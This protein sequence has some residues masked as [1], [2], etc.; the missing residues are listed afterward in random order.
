M[1]RDAGQFNGFFYDLA[2]LPVIVASAGAFLLLRWISEAKVFASPKAQ[3]WLRLLASTTF[4]IY[5]VHVLIIEILHGWIPGFRLDSFI[6]NPVW[7]IPLVSAVV[8]LISL[9]L[10]QFLQKIPV[11]KQIVPG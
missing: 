4:G 1:T 6:G 3:D 11:L 8:F 7:S 2:S 10:V 5:L 9:L